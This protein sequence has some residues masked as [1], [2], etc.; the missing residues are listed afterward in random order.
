[1]RGSSRH[2]WPAAIVLAAPFIFATGVALAAE[3]SGALSHATGS[4][5]AR[6][7]LPASG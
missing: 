2:P 4:S 3:A 1:M 7:A 6:F 5:P